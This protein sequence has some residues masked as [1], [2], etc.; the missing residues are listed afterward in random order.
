MFI[1]SCIMFNWSV[2][3]VINRFLVYLG[4]AMATLLTVS[5]RFTL[6]SCTFHENYPI[7]N[8]PVVRVYVY[9]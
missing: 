6:L 4:I 9:Q 8:E 2:C 5:N 1:V 7:L 3:L